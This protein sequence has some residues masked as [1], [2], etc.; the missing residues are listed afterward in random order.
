MTD[1]IV[2]VTD[3]QLAALGLVKGEAHGIPDIT[4][5]LDSLGL[6]ATECLP[7]GCAANTA[8]GLSWLGILAGFVGTVG[9][10][11][12]GRNYIRD[13]RKHRVR[14][15]VDVVEGESGTVHVLI[16]PDGERTMTWGGTRGVHWMHNSDR[17]EEVLPSFGVLYTTGFELVENPTHTLKHIDVAGRR[18]AITAFDLAYTA[19][20]RKYPELFDRVLRQ[21]DIAFANEDEAIACQGSVDAAVEQFNL[22]G[23]VAVVKLGSKGSIVSESSNPCRIPCIKADPFLNTLGAGDA[24]AAGFLAGLVEG[25]PVDEC[26]HRGS[27]FAA[28]V[29]GQ[30][31]PRMP[32]HTA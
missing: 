22:R 8:A 23:A 27:E 12:Y 24:Y 31:G 1:I 15:Y 3:G 5:R 19:G 14:P 17:V 25:R 10:D 32:P 21:V 16:T 29:C 13:L 6:K 26:G 4:A 18:G 28:K 30:E 2:Q 9:R 11:L 7:G 20:I